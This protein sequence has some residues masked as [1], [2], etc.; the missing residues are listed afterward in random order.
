MTPERLPDRAHS[1]GSCCP[2]HPLQ[3]QLPGAS[4]RAIHPV[5]S[6]IKA[7]G[8]RPAQRFERSHHRVSTRIPQYEPRDQ[9]WRTIRRH[10]SKQL[11][12]V[13]EGLEPPALGVEL[14]SNAWCPNAIY[15]SFEHGWHGRPPSRKAEN[16]AVYC[17]QEINVF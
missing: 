7:L 15:V 3:K 9:P 10:Y 16:N 4:S 17:A 13:Q 2:P 6:E 14:E 5:M 1:H 11:D 8:F 12:M